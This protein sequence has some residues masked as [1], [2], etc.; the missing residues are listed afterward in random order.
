MIYSELDELS[1]F[2]IKWAIFHPFLYDD[3]GACIVLEE[4]KRP[5]GRIFYSADSLKQKSVYRNAD[6]IGHYPDT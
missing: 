3:D 6:Q 1:M 4:N 2:N 5:Y